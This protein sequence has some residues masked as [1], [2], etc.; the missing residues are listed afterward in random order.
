MPSS[1]LCGHQVC[2]WSIDIYTSNAHSHEI[3]KK[4]KVYDV[5]ICLNIQ[6]LAGKMASVGKNACCRRMKT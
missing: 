5:N 2:T 3:K 6:S 4:V 1:T